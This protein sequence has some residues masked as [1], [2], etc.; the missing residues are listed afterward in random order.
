[1]ILS[2]FFILRNF[3]QPLNAEIPQ[4]LD[5]PTELVEA[6][7]DEGERSLF[8]WREL[9]VARNDELMN[10]ITQRQD[11]W[12]RLHGEV[13]KTGAGDKESGVKESGSTADRD[14][15]SHLLQI[16]SCWGRTGYALVRSAQLL[17]PLMWRTQADDVT[18]ELGLPPLTITT[19]DL[20]FTSL[21]RYFYQV[22]S[23]VL[24]SLYN[25]AIFSSSETTGESPLSGSQIPSILSSQPDRMHRSRVPKSGV[26][27]SGVPKSGVTNFRELRFEQQ[28]SST[29]DP[30]EQGR[31]H[32]ISKA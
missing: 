4:R 17:A 9:N 25:H 13:T 2:H 24:P 28:Q 3:V 30:L 16:F 8:E 19:I 7:L 29:F 6:L 12:D 31:R 11:M 27:K 18:E 14:V 23:H 26:T 22:S 1:M 32:S 10:G 20:N 15:V 5:L 21:E